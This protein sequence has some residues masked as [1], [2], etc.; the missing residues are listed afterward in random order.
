MYLMNEQTPGQS[1]DN[2]MPSLRTPLILLGCAVALFVVLAAYATI[3]PSGTFVSH[4]VKF[5]DASKGG[6]AIV[7]ASCPS[8]PGDADAPNGCGG[9]GTVYVLC[10][11]GS[12]A[13]DNT[14]SACGGAYTNGPSPL[15][16]TGYVMQNGGCV[17]GTS[18][19]PT[20]YQLENGQCV[21]TQSNCPIGFSEE[22]NSCVFTGCPGGYTYSQA[23]QACILQ[24][25]APAYICGTD[26]NQYL[27]SSDC[28][29]TLVQQCAWGCYQGAC[30]GEPTTS[31]DIVASPPLLKSGETTNVT[32]AASNVKSCTVTGTNGDGQGWS[33]Q[34]SACAATSSELSSPIIAQTIYTM[35]CTAL[36][37]STLTQSATVN[38]IPDFEEK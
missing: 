25:C 30:L 11:D 22:N 34:G 5:T 18:S 17:P 36:D 10:P 20:G 32:W 15:C 6:L 13:P 19:C 31:G 4:E 28:Q 2:K 16:P 35:T 14:L 38:I 23:Q 3:A 37:G 8:D 26:G 7:P 29:A 27:E 1:T 33:C 24:Q 21:N 12:L 9:P